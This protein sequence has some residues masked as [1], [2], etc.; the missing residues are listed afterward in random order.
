MAKSGAARD[1]CQYCGAASSSAA[2]SST[3][4]AAVLND[5]ERV[6]GGR[7]NKLGVGLRRRRDCVRT[8]RDVDRWC[9]VQQQASHGPMRL[10][11]C[12]CLQAQ[13]QRPVIL[14]NAE[15]GVGALLLRDTPLS[16][17]FA[18]LTTPLTLTAPLADALSVA[19]L[20]PF[21]VLF[22]TTETVQAPRARLGA[23]LTRACRSF[24]ID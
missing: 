8:R 1:T 23:S 15:A 19:L 20:P 9:S 11:A 17:C 18:K 12:D 4:A 3:A 5:T 21:R 16:L 14:D 7:G 2:S 24:A 6:G 22:L 10:G 13:C